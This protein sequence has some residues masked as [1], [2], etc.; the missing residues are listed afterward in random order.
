[1]TIKAGLE[2][3]YVDAVTSDHTLLVKYDNGTERRIDLGRIQYGGMNLVTYEAS[4]RGDQEIFSAFFYVNYK[5]HELDQWMH[6]DL[7]TGEKIEDYI[8][9][10]QASK[11]HPEEFRKITP[12]NMELVKDKLKKIMDQIDREIKENK[13]K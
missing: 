10:M 13:S 3:V 12:E 1:M 4:R 7:V 8:N 11:K 5:G 2:R 9:P 6:F